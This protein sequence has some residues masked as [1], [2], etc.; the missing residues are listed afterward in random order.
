[1][2]AKHSTTRY[3]QVRGF[4]EYRVGEDGS[5]W[6]KKRFGYWRRL[7]PRLTN[8]YHSV[9]LYKGGNQVPFQRYV[10][11]LVLEAFVG[12]CPRGMECCHDDGDRANNDLTNLRWDFHVENEKDKTRHGTLIRGEDRPG[13]KLKEQQ[14]SKVRSMYKT[15][16]YTMK[17][18]AGSFG[19]S[20]TTI[21]KVL[22]GKRWSHVA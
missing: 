1:M 10:H 8:G 9:C 11:R 21:Q 18:V 7:K 12:K 4:G 20:F 17:E 16:K 13:C 15:G 22:S 19:V 5:V 6:S 14:I 2:S 3:C